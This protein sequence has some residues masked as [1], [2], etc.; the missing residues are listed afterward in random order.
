MNAVTVVDFVARHGAVL[1]LGATIVLACGSVGVAL[2]S[3]P[4]ARRWLGVRTVLAVGVYLI[5]AAIPL[6]RLGMFAEGGVA[7]VT[8]VVDATASGITAPA[9]D[10]RGHDLRPLAERLAEFVPV[11][12]ARPAATPTPGFDPLRLLAASWCI[13]SVLVALWLCAG[14]IRLARLLRSARAARP[15]ELGGVDVPRR[16]RVSFVARPIRPFCCGLL[17]PCVVL[18]ESLAGSGQAATR[19]AVL[20]HEFAH[21]RARDPEAQ[22]LFALLLPVLFFHP[23]LWWLR[24]EVRF[25]S[26]VLADA[27]AVVDGE[28]TD[29]AR[30]LLGLAA[31]EGHA[32]PL[33]VSLFR[34]R[35]EFFRRMNMLLE[36]DCELR[37]S[38]S[39]LRRASQAIVAVV[40]LAT[41][42][43]FLGVRAPAQ[44]P[45][46]D[47]VRSLREENAKLRAQI[48]D[49]RKSID[50]L[51]K[52]MARQEKPQP[53]LDDVTATQAA[54]DAAKPPQLPLLTD[55]P[56]LN[57]LFVAD[58]SGLPSKVVE[59]AV[60]PTATPSRSDPIARAPDDLAA[61]V[62]LATRL[63]DLDAE[64]RLAEAELATT[65]P[66]VD[67]G[68]APVQDK[69]RVQLRLESAQRKQKIVRAIVADEMA[70]TESEIA[71][72]KALVEKGLAPGGD[73][74][75]LERRL[76]LLHSM[77]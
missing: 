28:R 24:K 52:A 36:R 34:R 29:Y 9:V 46:G 44:E 39:R 58:A 75:R 6:P 38:I 60:D 54:T 1:L 31:S 4:F 65:G 32:P 23:V 37:V 19:A 42:G 13:G 12:H 66:L 77:L 41:C 49:L 11:T 14:R 71:R 15:E 67:S 20:R 22:V 2:Q 47:T 61:L 73:L 17:R 33:A 48:E 18:P 8:S 35:S 43:A 7:E 25:A 56:L 57:R 76:R 64:A 74:Q 50:A 51:T 59:V 45:G 40:V 30:S 62:D 26:E 27:T 70:A 3:Q 5:L 68:R 10:L 21:L 69:L 53:Q 63:V 55:L 72:S 16:T